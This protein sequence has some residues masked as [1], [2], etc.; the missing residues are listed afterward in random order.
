MLKSPLHRLILSL[1]IITP[2]AWATPELI[3]SCEDLQQITNLY[4]DYELTQDIDCAGMT[5]RPIQGNFAATFD[6]KGFAISNLNIKAKAGA[7]AG[8]FESLSSNTSSHKPAIKNLKIHHAIVTA[9]DDSAR[10]VLAGKAHGASLSDVFIDQVEFKGNSS[11]GYNKGGTGTL[12]GETR[13][14]RIENAHVK[15]VKLKLHSAAGG[16]VGKSDGHLL[17]SDASAQQLTSYVDRNHW[18]GSGDYAYGI[19]GLVG[20]AN[21][22]KNEL[23]IN[24]S[25]A[26]GSLF[27]PFNAGG[28]VGRANGY[29][30]VNI[31]DSYSKVDV[32]A[33]EYAGGIIGHAENLESGNL[34]EVRL[35]RVYA[36]G[37]VNVAGSNAGRGMVGDHSHSGQR[38]TGFNSFFDKETTGRKNSGD[39]GSKGLTTEKMTR[40]STYDNWS[41]NVWLIEDGKY[42]VLR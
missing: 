35:H 34:Y 11:P 17:I 6:G 19:G 9:D 20:I 22:F 31:L 10:G 32:N 16:L 30:T 3:T 8:I 27:S 37:A 21:N 4:A 38:S 13:N 18:S 42:P 25:F 14:T 33:F 24:K 12:F 26:S 15:S 28:L 29:A 40:A 7:P 23:F 36:R 41:S 39:K 2:S 5:F 1:A